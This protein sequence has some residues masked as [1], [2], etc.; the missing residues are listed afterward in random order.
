MIDK[1]NHF[2]TF[3]KLIV[4]YLQ[5]RSDILRLNVEPNLMKV[6]EAKK[7]FEQLKKN[8]KKGIYVQVLK[9]LV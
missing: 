6:A 2:T 9:V 3:G 7:T 5:Y 8:I 4:S 1:N